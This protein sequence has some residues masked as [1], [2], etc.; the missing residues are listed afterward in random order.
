MKFHLNFNE[1]GAVGHKC[2]SSG[3]LSLRQNTGKYSADSSNLVG[4]G[5]LVASDASPGWG[6]LSRETIFMSVE[7]LAS[8]QTCVC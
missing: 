4:S 1:D 7:A 2:T 6:E 5:L 8:A 3:M